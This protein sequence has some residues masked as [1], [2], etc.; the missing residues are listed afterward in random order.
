MILE[1]DNLLLT[2][3]ITIYVYCKMYGWC[4]TCRICERFSQRPVMLGRACFT[5]YSLKHPSFD[6]DEKLLLSVV[7]WLLFRGFTTSLRVTALIEKIN[8]NWQNWWIF[9]ID[10]ESSS[11]LCTLKRSLHILNNR[12][13][14]FFIFLSEKCFSNHYY[15]YDLNIHRL[16][17]ETFFSRCTICSSRNDESKAF[18]NI[19]YRGNC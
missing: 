17:I 5:S 7:A 2:H 8:G 15:H 1:R 9:N 13:S 4:R 16:W 11:L 19:S 12:Y 18:R 6:R 3:L 10:T 14:V